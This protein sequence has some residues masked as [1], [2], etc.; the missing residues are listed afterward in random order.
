M[1]YPIHAIFVVVYLLVLIGIGAMKAGKIKNQADFSLAGRGLTATILIGTMLATWIGTGSIFGNSEQTYKLGLGAFILPLGGVLGMILLYRLADRIRRLEDFTIQDI[2]ERRFGVATRIIGTICLL[3]AYVIIVSYQYR[4]GSAVLER[5]FP[6]LSH[7]WAVVFV[8]VFVIAYTALAGMYSVAYTDVA[9]G[10]LMVVGIFIAIPFLWFKVQSGGGLESLPEAHR[11]VTSGWSFIHIVNW[12]LPTLLLILGDANMYQRFFSAKDPAAAKRAAG[13]L[14]IGIAVLDCAIILLALLGRTL[15]EQGSIQAP[16]IPGQIVVSIAFEA[17]PAFLGAMLMATIVAIVVSTA[18]S[19]LLAPSTSV[20]RD[21]YKRFLKPAAS[22]TE[23]VMVGR[24]V[25][26]L[27]GLIALGLA[28]TGDSFFKIALFAYTIYGASITPVI[29]AAFFWRRATRM[30]AVAS[31]L[32]GVGAAL[33][34]QTLQHFEVTESWAD[35]T[36][37]HWL[38]SLDAVLPALGLSLGV[39]ILVSYLQPALP[40]EEANAV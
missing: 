24:G 8:A 5:I 30:G 32:A 14:I 28:F 7:V 39:L 29:I 15:V 1:Q 3:L 19:F 26:V 10:I 21:V 20:V 27:F 31:M 25:V 13:W 9:N 12:C 40:A 33:L 35:A 2:L 23:V 4:A 37:W 11:A 18:D 22:E 17:L 16:E 34:W 6:S 38:A 36:G